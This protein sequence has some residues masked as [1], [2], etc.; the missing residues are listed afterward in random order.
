MFKKPLS[1]LKSLSALRSSD[2]R[3][4]K[5]RVMS[6]FNLSPEDGDLLVPD[7]IESVK[8]K[9]HLEELGVAYLSSDGDPLWFTIGK[10]SDEL[11]PT[12]YTLWKKDDLLPFLSTPAAVIPILAG[13]TDLMTPEVV[14]HPPSLAEGT[15]VSIRQYSRKDDKVYLSVPLAVGRMA[16]P[17]DQLTSGGKEQEKAVLMTHVWKDYLWDMGSKPDVPDDK[18]VQI[19]GQK[20]ESS[21]DEPGSGNQAAAI[22][23]PPS[24]IDEQEP[25]ALPSDAGV[26]YTP[27]EISELLQKSLLQAITGPLAS[28]PASNYPI[29]VTQFYTNYILPSRPAFPTLVLRPSSCPGEDDESHIDPQSISIKTS[30]HKSLT[31]FLKASEKLGLV[32]VKHPQKHS[33]QTDSLV[34]SVD[35]KHSLVQSHVSFL[36]VGDREAK[37]AEKAA[38]EEKER[39]EAEDL[40]QELEIREW[41]EPHL[42]TVDLFKGLGGNPSGPYT[43]TEIRSLVFDYV[44][45][46]DL[47]NK[48]D[49][50]Y[51]NLDE[52]FSACLAA[53]PGGKSK[54]KG[55]GTGSELP[56][57]IK[58]D[59]L[60]KKI[61]AKMQAWYEIRAPGK[62]PVPEKGQLKPI[63][64]VTKIREGTKASTM[65]TGFEPFLVDAEEMAEDL[66]KIC[67]GATGISPIAGKPAGSGKEVLVQGKQAPAVVQY[68]MAAA[69]M[70]PRV[71]CSL[72]IIFLAVFTSALPQAATDGVEYVEL[73]PEA[74]DASRSGSGG[75]R[76]CKRLAVRK[77]WRDLSATHKRDYIRAVKCLQQRRALNTTLPN[78]FNRFDEFS[79]SHSNAAERVHGVGQF[80]PWHRHFGYLHHQALRDCNYAG[81]FP[82]WDWTRDTN[83]NTPI[84]QS[85]L[86]D[87]VTGFGGDGVAGTYTPPTDDDGTPFPIIP[88]FM[89]GCVQTGPFANLVLHVGPGR[90]FT[91]HCLVR[92][93][94][95]ELRPSL[96]QP[97]ISNIMSQT[98][99]DNFW[100]SLDGLPFKPDSRLHDAGHG[101]TGGDMISFYTSP[102]DPIFFLH[103][104]G[105]DRIWWQ[106]QNADLNNRLYQIGGRVNYQ[107]PFGEVTLDYQLPYPGLAT[108]WVTLRDAMDPRLEPYC[109]TY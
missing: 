54:G 28:A 108:P 11:I 92:G 30:T 19:S 85:P 90:R 102:N 33:Q 99:Y 3:K 98:T 44:T 52:L 53:Q 45:A 46:R 50:K 86:F 88:E 26:S 58:R 7:G 41:W 87:P 2:R 63:Q 15:L 14:H 67:A 8:F 9:S 70:I 25:Q 94:H 20:A 82:Y 4:L 36:T 56:K 40:S 60:V 32:T 49:Q 62:D 24:E 34:M 1:N 21:Q 12:I 18:A 59:D 22:S 91:D 95:E 29:P 31:L 93:F 79:L 103:H 73:E 80:L 101:F 16:L 97:H 74:T 71:L 23:P 43:P 76:R 105:L 13:G 47:I 75:P 27:E 6:A 48:E 107:P 96:S 55:Q 38:R 81:P 72:L 61:I 106:W 64:V 89:K 104:A 69:L 5:Q 42:V 57:L 65:I 17:S 109:Y 78:K 39:L 84:Q 77:E 68:L 37:A 83:G 51:I 66:R 35:A 10:G 100:N